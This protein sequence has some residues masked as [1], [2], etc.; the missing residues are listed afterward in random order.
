MRRQCPHEPSR[1]GSRRSSAVA[2]RAARYW[3]MFPRFSSFA[4]VSSSASSSSV[5]RLSC[6]V[7]GRC[8]RWSKPLRQRRVVDFRAGPPRKRSARLRRTA[9][10]QR[11]PATEPERRAERV[12]AGS[13]WAPRSRIQ[14]TRD[15]WLWVVSRQLGGTKRATTRPKGPWLDRSGA[16]PRSGIESRPCAW[17]KAAESPRAPSRG[18]PAAAATDAA[19]A[20]AISMSGCCY[21]SCY[22]F[23]RNRPD[24]PHWSSPELR[25]P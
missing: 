3:R 25:T 22:Q 24:Q 8:R 14:R 16:G 10:P 11:L 1:H 13:Q 21:R 7:M 17:A 18:G 4:H 12:R 5:G 9:R 19:T 20:R 15:L 23:N 2:A 6:L